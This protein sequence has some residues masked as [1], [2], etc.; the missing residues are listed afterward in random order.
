MRELLALRPWPIGAIS[1]LLGAVL[2]TAF[3]PLSGRR[4]VPVL[5]GSDDPRWPRAEQATMFDS[6]QD[7]AVFQS[8]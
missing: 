7:L 4:R 8:A 6:D 2:S 3:P 1:S 5:L